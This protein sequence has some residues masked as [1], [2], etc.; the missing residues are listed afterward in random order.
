M[1][2]KLG[3]LFTYFQ[4]PESIRRSPHS[5]NIIERRNKE[6]RR[7]IKVIDYLPSES[8]AMRIIYHRVAELKEK[9]SNGVINRY[10]KCK[11]QINDKFSGK[12]SLILH[13]IPV[14][15]GNVY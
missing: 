6:I 4:Y 7:R 15:T 2:K 10:Y 5:S 13:I 14:T 9:W 1:E 8:T 12:G 3:Y 11:G